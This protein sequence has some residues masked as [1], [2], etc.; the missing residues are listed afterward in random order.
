MHVECE[1]LTRLDQPSLLCRSQVC[2]YP[3]PKT[4]ESYNAQSRTGPGLRPGL[5]SPVPELGRRTGGQSQSPTALCV[6]WGDP[7]I[8]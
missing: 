7:T 6:A 2:R 5:Q 4:R 8:P 3:A 1:G